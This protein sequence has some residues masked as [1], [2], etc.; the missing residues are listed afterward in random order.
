MPENDMSDFA[1]YLRCLY[2]TAPEALARDQNNMYIICQPEKPSDVYSYGMIAFEVLTELMPFENTV[3]L[4]AISQPFYLLAAVKMNNLRPIIPKK[5]L[6]NSVHLSNVIR[7][8][9]KKEPPLRPS[10]ADIQKLMRVANPKHRS[11]IDS[12]MQAIELYAQRL[13]E[14]V[15]ERTKELEKLTD[16][17]ESLL[18][19][20]L[21]PSIADKLAKGL[22]VEPEFYDSSTIFFSDIVDF[23]SLSA[24]S[25][26]IDIVTL[27]ND[28][29]SAFD[30]VIQRFDVYK[31][32]TIGDSYM[33]ISGLPNRNGSEHANQIASMSLDMLFTVTTIPIRH[34][35][36]RKLQIRIGAHTGAV[37][38]GVVGITMP[39][40]CLFGD[41][42]NTAS[43]MESSSLPMRIQI[44]E[45]TRLLLEF[46]NIYIIVTRGAFTIKGKGIMKT[47]WLVG[48][49]GYANPL[50]TLDPTQDEQLALLLDE[51][52]LK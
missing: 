6:L 45:A 40:Y 42:V 17:M 46:L 44:S 22:T 33:C 48:K 39:R 38:A 13:E 12:M 19:S 18:H 27:L 16:N 37:V 29:Y 52:Q 2:W 32:E 15:A 28:L 24:A 8:T 10:F 3:E 5:T 1:E 36:E 47:Y 25:S 14:K 51:A 26:P 49:Q 23:T 50:P 7:A 43:R 4:D 35:P 30:G 9:W 21:P 11:I 41:S 20:M 31:V 34:M